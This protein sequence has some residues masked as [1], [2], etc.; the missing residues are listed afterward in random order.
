MNKDIDISKICS[1]RLIKLCIKDAHRKLEGWYH[2]LIVRG[3][4]IQRIGDCQRVLDSNYTNRQISRLCARAREQD[5][6]VYIDSRDEKTLTFREY[7]FFLDSRIKFLEDNIKSSILEYDRLI[8]EKKHREHKISELRHRFYG[9]KPI[10][11]IK[12]EGMRI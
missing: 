11:H 8:Q 7:K 6:L 10:K 9:R 1:R 3:M 5:A 12:T 2:P 4:G